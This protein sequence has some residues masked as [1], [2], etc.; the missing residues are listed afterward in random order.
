MSFKLISWGVIWMK[1]FLKPGHV[2]SGR[3]S[4]D[5]KFE[6]IIFIKIF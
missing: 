1:L 6:M 4:Y 5:Q 2:A 3:L